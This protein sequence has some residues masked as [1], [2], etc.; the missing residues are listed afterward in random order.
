[1]RARG[2][3]LLGWAS[4]FGPSFWIAN[5][6]ELFERIAFY[7]MFSMLVVYLTE[8]RG[9]EPQAAL[10]LYG[11][12][13][14]LVWSLPVLSGFLADL[15]GYR[16][17]MILAYGLLVAGYLATG[18]A[19]SYG[20]VAAALLP[21]AAG[22]SIIKPVVAGTVQKTSAEE[23]RPVGFSIYY[24]L[25]N[26]GGFV[27]PIAGARVREKFG[28]EKAFVLSA[29]ASLIALLVAASAFREPPREGGNSS[30][31]LGQ[32]LGDF[33][34]V[35]KNGRLM[36][37]FLFVAGFWSLFFQF[38]GALPLYLRDD[39]EVAPVLLGLIPA[40]DAAAIIGLQ[41]L[42]GALTRRLPTPLALFLAV[43]ISSAGI[44]TIGLRASAVA[45][46]AGVVVFALGEMIY[47]AH[48]YKYLGDLAPPGQ[49]GLYMGFA[50]LP[51]AAGNFL[52]GQIGGAFTAYFRE[53]LGRPQAMW[54]AFAGI[55]FA[56]A[57][58]IALV[59]LVPGLWRR[60]AMTEDRP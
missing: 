51:I 40:L 43:A 9:I 54:F 19:G 28:V 2:G 48:F 56:S 12:F 52:A 34:A 13:G 58:G 47:S 41:V 6:T 1:M 18:A 53:T 25:V 17:S 60:G 3:R 49:T 30:R 24:T 8:A 39:L 57:A 37:L 15:A 22:A 50:F 44:A 27:G 26:I 10:R 46:A 20:L 11:T 16:R 59:A 32:F 7:A 45:A 55:G 29:G 21:V 42:V 23:L 4:R 35:V 5:L 38:F 36:L 31:N 33:L 14:L